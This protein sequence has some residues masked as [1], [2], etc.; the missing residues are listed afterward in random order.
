MGIA[1]AIGVPASDRISFISATGA[2]PD[3][4]VEVTGNYAEVR[5]AEGPADRPR[6]CSNWLTD[7]SQ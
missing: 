3:S 5:I 1:V 7:D 6:L 2:E 4:I